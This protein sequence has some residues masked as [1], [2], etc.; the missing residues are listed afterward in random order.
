MNK[1]V[2]YGSIIGGL[3]ILTTTGAIITGVMYPEYVNYTQHKTI[4]NYLLGDSEIE[5]TV[6][7]KDY[8]KQYNFYISSLT[9][10]DKQQRKTQQKAFKNTYPNLESYL[11]TITANGLITISDSQKSYYTATYN[12]YTK[13]DLTKQL[14]QDGVIAGSVILALSVVGMIPAGIFLVKEN[15]KSKNNNSEQSYRKSY[16]N[17]IP[18]KSPTPSVTD[19][20][21][22]AS[23]Y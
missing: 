8:V 13:G 15:N 14:N 23:L 6:S 10:T 2:L 17:T 11:D 3:G 20:H 9:D 7:F 5:A 21:D 1:K 4:Y 22:R 19:K 12:I 16:N 18:P